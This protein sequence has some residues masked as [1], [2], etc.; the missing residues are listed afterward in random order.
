MLLF[1]NYIFIIIYNW[2]IFFKL[3]YSRFQVQCILCWNV[4]FVQYCAEVAFI[5]KI[6]PSFC[7]NIYSPENNEMIIL[8]ARALIKSGNFLPFCLFFIWNTYVCERFC[9]ISIFF[10]DF[11]AVFEVDVSTLW[12]HNLKLW[13]WW[14]CNTELVMAT[15]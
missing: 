3:P 13:G 9:R 8:P 2:C 10:K 11:Q 6:V 7:Q 4:L 5:L 15:G 14:S 1:I 12:N